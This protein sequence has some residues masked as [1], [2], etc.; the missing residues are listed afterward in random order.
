MSLWRKMSG[1]FLTTYKMLYCLAYTFCSGDFSW[2][3]LK[4]KFLGGCDADQTNR[5]VKRLS[6]LIVMLLKRLIESKKIFSLKES[7]KPS[8]FQT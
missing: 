6:N 8:K 4:R 3:S 2:F 5:S 7:Q 1:I